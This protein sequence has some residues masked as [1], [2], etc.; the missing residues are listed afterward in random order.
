MSLSLRVGSFDANGQA[1]STSSVEPVAGTDRV[2]RSLNRQQQQQQQQQQQPQPPQP[3]Y[4]ALIANPKPIGVRHSPSNVRRFRDR[5]GNS[6]NPAFLSGERRRR[7]SPLTVIDNAPGMVQ[8][9]NYEEARASSPSRGATA[10]SDTTGERYR[11]S[12]SPPPQHIATPQLQTGARRR[13]HAVGG[14]GSRASEG[15]LQ[16]HST[17]LAP[18]SNFAGEEEES[19]EGVRVVPATESPAPIQAMSDHLIQA[20]EEARKLLMNA[21]SP[22][23]GGGSGSG[24]GGAFAGGAAATALTLREA[25]MVLEQETILD[26]LELQKRYKESLQQL[27]DK[28][29]AEIHALRSEMERSKKIHKLAQR[30]HLG[31]LKEQKEQMH[32]LEQSIAVLR[33]RNTDLANLVR[34]R[35]RPQESNGSHNHSASVAVPLG[36]ES[37]ASEDERGDP[38]AQNFSDPSSALNTSTSLQNVNDYFVNGDAGAAERAASP[39]R[40]QEATTSGVDFIANSNSDPSDDVVDIEVETLLC[41]ITQEAFEDPVVAADGHT[42]E[43]GGILQWLEKHD[44]SPLTGAQLSSKQLFTNWTLR[45]ILADYRST[46]LARH[47]ATQAAA[48]PG[49]SSA[50]ATASNA[51]RDGSRVQ[52]PARMDAGDRTTAPGAPASNSETSAW[53]EAASAL[54]QDRDGIG[55]NSTRISSYHRAL[56]LDNSTGSQT[57]VIS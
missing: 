11:P 20:F 34:Q 51:N 2:Q 12:G 26:R 16:S 21:G 10:S 9:E 45:S 32:T 41:P 53:Q 30:Y 52:L 50:A 1:V 7:T 8:D 46:F 4:R 56:S 40:N 22:S 55:T 17:R 37:L 14:G 25:L 5:W 35:H 47:R 27:E 23:N 6:T 44:T 36:S 43:R 49:P 13:S 39:N 33:K 31:R 15:S 54:V 57:C 24:G 18:N 29:G 28:Y 48:T 3:V 19:P 38:Q 42:Y